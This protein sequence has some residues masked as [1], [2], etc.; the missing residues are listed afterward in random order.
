MNATLL[1]WETEDE[2]ED[3]NEQFKQAMVQAF[4]TLYKDIYEVDK[5]NSLENYEQIVSSNQEE[6]QSITDF[7]QSM[8][9]MSTEELV[10]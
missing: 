3:K 6:F 4:P 2:N 8:H 10:E 7:L 5:D 9:T 1:I